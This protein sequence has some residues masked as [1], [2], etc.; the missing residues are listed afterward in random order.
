[1]AQCDSAEHA[2]PLAEDDDLPLLLQRDLPDELTDLEQL[3]R[4]KPLDH[5]LLGRAAT[6]RRPDVVE[7]ELRQAVGDDPLGGQQAHHAEK[8]GLG[9]GPD[10]GTLDERDDRLD[11][12]IVLLVLRIGHLDRHA[13]VG[14]GRELVEHVLTDATDQAALEPLAERVEMAHADDLATAVGVDGVE[15][16][17]APLRL[18]SPV[19]DPLDDRC[20]FLDAVLHRRAGEH[21]AIGGRQAL[22][23]QG[24]LGRPVLDALRLVEHDE[25]R[26]PEANRLQVAEDLLIIDDEDT[27]AC[28]TVT[29]LPLGGGTVDDRDRK[30]G[31][32]GPLARPLRFERRRGDD[33]STADTASAPEDVAAGDRLGRL[34][35]AH[36]VGQEE[37][38]RRQEPFDA[39]PLV[40]IQRSLEPLDRRL[41]FRGRGG[42]RDDP[43]QAVALAVEQGTQGRVVAQV[44]APV[45]R[46]FRTSSTSCRR[47]AGFSA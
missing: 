16:T 41:E 40:R 34:A 13:G 27:G 23:R 42:L 47:F 10:L 45:G 31:E 5:A 18:Q 21:Q 30:L 15:G 4:G 35:Q 11:Q 37:V 3:W 43:F 14:P 32:Q 39:L 28:G 46:T 17:Q 36:V 24:G 26:G 33:Q 6:D 7:P 25:V 29:L 20:Q 12:R 22:D 9:Q 38:A 19:V 44:R 8:L 1:M 2:P